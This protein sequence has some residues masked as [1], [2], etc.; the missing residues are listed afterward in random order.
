MHDSDSFISEVSEEVRRDRLYAGLRRYRWLIAALVLLIVGGAAFNEWRKARDRAAAEAAGDALRT[1]F[2]EADPATRAGLLEDAAVAD[3]Q[4]AALA[5][6]AEAGSR[7]DAGDTDAAAALL[8]EVAGDGSVGELYRSLASLQRVMLLGDAMPASEREA[9]LQMLAAPN[10]PFRPLALE[11][12]ALMHLD[13][14]DK[15][16]AIAD[17]QAAIEEP[18]ATDALRGRA[19]QL[20][21]AAGGTLP[22]AVPSADG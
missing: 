16:A 6:L 15:D 3:P 2:A 18:D 1:A 7:A 11:Q 20:I 22:T 14:G 10:A 9:T 8:E 5:K 4:A 13:G 19:R 21:I 12:R 17:L